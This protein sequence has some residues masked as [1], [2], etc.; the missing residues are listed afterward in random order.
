LA[1]TRGLAPYRS[2]IG[3]TGGA[4]EAHLDVQAAFGWRVRGDDRVVGGGDG[5]DDGQ[6]KSVPAAVAGAGGVQPLER[7]EEPVDL[8]GRDLWAA[9]GDRQD[10]ATIPGPGGELDRAAWDI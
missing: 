6:A 2:A 3:R 1:A 4:R 7:L 10:G 5:G 9:A 8:G